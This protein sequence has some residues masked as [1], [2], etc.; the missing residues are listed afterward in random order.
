MIIKNNNRIVISLLI[1]LSAF[2]LF[3]FTSKKHTTKNV[4]I[5]GTSADFQ[6]FS[7]INENNEIVGFDIDIIKE[8]AKRINMNL[9]IKDQ[10]FKMLLPQLQNG[11][12]DVIA[13]GMTPTEERKKMINFTEPHLKDN[14]LIAISN[15]SSE[16]EIKNIEDLKKYKII[17]NTGY[18][19]DIYFSNLGEFDLTRL[20]KPIDAFLTLSYKKSHIF[21][22]SKH[23]AKSFIEKDKNNQYNIFEIPN[24]DE[25]SAIGMSLKL[26]PELKNK[27]E[28]AIDSMEKDGTIQAL[29]NKWNI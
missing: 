12:I 5:V 3:W 4:L 16:I 1:S 7:F 11:Y 6:P 20:D 2:S 17:V 27:I 15:K 26:S 9:E 23:S 10:S 19:A 14:P 25:P 29:K 21:L 8:V 18:T 24:T 28:K 22:I 13:A